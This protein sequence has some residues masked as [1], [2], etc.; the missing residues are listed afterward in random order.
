MQ[1]TNSLQNVFQLPW[2]W[3]GFYSVL[4]VIR[5]WRCHQL[6]NTQLAHFT[7]I[8]VVEDYFNFIVINRALDICR[9]E[10]VD[11]NR[12]DRRRRVWIHLQNR[13]QAP[14]LRRT[15]EVPQRD[16]R[17]LSEAHEALFDWKK[18]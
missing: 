17:D 15:G 11:S 7:F 1:T 8:W 2:S 3:I 16:P 4:F 18:R 6:S 9:E 14:Q 10:K 5:P 12:E 13:L